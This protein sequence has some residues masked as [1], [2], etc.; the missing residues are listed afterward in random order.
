MVQRA[1]RQHQKWTKRS[2]IVIKHA[3]L[4]SALSLYYD[5]MAGSSQECSVESR[6]RHLV[7]SF[8]HAQRSGQQTTMSVNNRR[9][10]CFEVAVPY[11]DRQVQWKKKCN[12]RAKHPLLLAI[13]SYKSAESRPV[14]EA[15]LGFR[16]EWTRLWGEGRGDSGLC[17]KHWMS[18][19]FDAVNLDLDLD[20][21][22]KRCVFVTVLCL[23]THVLSLCSSLSLAHA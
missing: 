20:L 6:R 7:H 9:H 17:R 2:K 23:Q 12:N 5:R 3:I 15:G 11:T 21:H 13:F 10:L 16:R 18:M 22:W 19:C 4:F 14:N 1:L 8:G